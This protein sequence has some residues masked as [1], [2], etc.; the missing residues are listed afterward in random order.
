MCRR[1]DDAMRL[2]ARARQMVFAHH[3]S[4]HVT[5]AG[6]RAEIIFTPKPPRSGADVP[7]GRQDDM[8]TLLHAFNM[9]EGILV[10]PF[11]TLLL[12]RLDS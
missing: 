2:A 4:W 7:A 5:Q 8:E 11:H 1:A 9:N 3:L 12:T 10:I 6:A